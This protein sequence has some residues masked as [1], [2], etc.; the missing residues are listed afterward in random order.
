MA[1]PAR[2]FLSD[3]WEVRAARGIAEAVRELDWNPH[4]LTLDLNF[5][6][7]DGGERV[8]D[9][10][11]AKRLRTVTVIVSAITEPSRLARLRDRYQPAAIL[12][13]PVDPAEVL[14]VCSLARPNE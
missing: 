1:G 7:D 12:S 13:K 14:R 4:C 6:Q 10:I 3:E 9:A 5:P 2:L 8:L 11:M